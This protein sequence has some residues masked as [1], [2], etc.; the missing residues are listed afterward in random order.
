MPRAVAFL[1]MTNDDRRVQQIIERS[2]QA[3]MNAARAIARAG[4]PEVGRDVALLRVDEPRAVR[5]PVLRAVLD[6]IDMVTLTLGAMPGNDAP[7][8]DEL[9]IATQALL[10]ALEPFAD[11][12]TRSR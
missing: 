1:S 3:A 10:A 11:T 5:Q 4:R 7:L 6:G 12:P 8:S 9:N 2:S